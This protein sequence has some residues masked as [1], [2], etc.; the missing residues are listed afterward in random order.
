MKVK[1][2]KLFSGD[3]RPAY[4]EDKDKLKK[5][6]PNQVVEVD[7]KV[8][9]NYKHLQK[10]MVLINTIFENQ[11]HYDNKEDL[12]RDLLI[13]CGFYREVVNIFTGEVTYV[14]KSLSFSK[15]EQHE[16]DDV[17]NKV[18]NKICD[19]MNWNNTELEENIAN[20]I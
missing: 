10:F 15:M 18:L 2:V 5:I 6:K 19:L 12:R 4:D 8:K 7:L 3:L 11:E 14:A 20:F 17:Y 13:A 9:R 16:F 1:L